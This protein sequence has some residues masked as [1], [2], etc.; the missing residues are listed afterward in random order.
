MA[1]IKVCSKIKFP[2]IELSYIEIDKL[3]EAV[4]LPVA[5]SLTFVP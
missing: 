3:A 4:R 5:T 1:L 2:P